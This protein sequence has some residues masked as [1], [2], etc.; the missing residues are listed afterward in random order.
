MEEFDQSYGYILYRKTV[1]YDADINCIKL[2]GIADRAHV[3]VNGV[4]SGIRMRDA[5]TSEIKLSECLKP[6][7][8][9]DILVENLGRICY[10]EE[11]YLGDRKGITESVI[12]TQV[13]PDGSV[14][15]PGK[16]VFNWDITTLELHDLSG[17]AFKS[18]A[19]G[20]LSGVLQGAF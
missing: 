18:G 7:D 14:R 17:V 1:D 20:K 5:D 4:L 11:T 8:T 10:G 9:V 16:T 15:F 2:K 6:G 3:F 19:P 13:F 12:F